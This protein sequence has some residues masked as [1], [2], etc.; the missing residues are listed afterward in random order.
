MNAIQENNSEIKKMAKV[1]DRLLGIEEYYF[2]TKL[3]QIDEMNRAGK[4]V[5]NL[6]SMG[7]RV[8][9]ETLSLEMQFPNGIKNGITWISILIQ[10]FCL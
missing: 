6:G 10:R 2:S 5:I 7:I 9:K 8:I 1:S 4:N 3:R